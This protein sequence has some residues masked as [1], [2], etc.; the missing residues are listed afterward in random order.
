MLK[1]N[2]YDFPDYLNLNNLQILE[3]IP[4]QIVDLTKV[5]IYTD[6]SLMDQGTASAFT[7]YYENRFIHDYSVRLHQ[8]NSIYQAELYAILL[9]IQWLS[10]SPFTS[11]L[12]LTDSKSSLDV[13]KIL[14]P[15]NKIIRQIYNELLNLPQK[16][17]TLT[18]IKAHKGTKGNERADQLAKNAILL[19]DYEEKVQLPFPESLVKKFFKDKILTDWQAIW[20]NSQKGRETYKILDK[21]DTSFICIP[22]Q[23]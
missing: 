1:E 9:S 17:I 19:N 21:V 3:D 4:Q 8:L 10:T 14:F 22:N 18:W 6:G 2:T 15:K 16:Q 20:K 12:I 11:A 7:V 23:G 13:L 5:K